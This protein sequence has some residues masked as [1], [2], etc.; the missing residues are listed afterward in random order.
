MIKV[1]IC[2]DMQPILRSIADKVSS[3]SS[4]IEIVGQFTNGK[5]ALESIPMLQPDIVFTDIRMPELD[6][7]QLIT[8]LKERNLSSVYIIFSGYND[9]QYARQ[10]LQLGVTEYLL[11]PITS[12]SITEI[13]DKTVPQVLNRKQQQ[14][15]YVLQYFLKENKTEG[16]SDEEIK[17]ALTADHFILGIFHAGPISKFD[18]HLSNPFSHFW[19]E[20]HLESFLQ[21]WLPPGIQ[22]WIFDSRDL[23]ELWVVFGCL[24]AAAP[25]FQQLYNQLLREYDDP[26]VP[27]TLTVSSRIKDVSGL[28]L[29]LQF[30]HTIMKKQMLFGRS[31]LIFTE[32][33]QLNAPV[34][35]VLEQG[36]EQ[37]LLSILKMNRKDDFLQT[38]ERLLLGW[39]NEQYTQKE[40]ESA[41]SSIITSC[42]KAKMF[43]PLLIS[44]INLELDE[45]ISI[46]A[47]YK[48]LYKNLAI[49][50][51]NIFFSHDSKEISPDS[52]QHTIRTIDSYLKEHYAEDISIHGIAE[53]FNISPSY[54]SREFKK[55]KGITPIEYLSRLRINKVKELLHDPANLKLKDIAAIVGYQNQYYLSKVFKLTTGMTTSEFKATGVK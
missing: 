27:L 16:V 51:D 9:F 5:A 53:Q 28:K 43:N 24:G 40:V 12:H 10:A 13:L 23:N 4:Q 47:D 21:K 6:G 55:Y 33:M 25:D 48:Q 49:L 22:S 52:I 34:R 38:I 30:S 7:L 1:V 44:D 36:N 46:S 54:L 11:K 41:L 50:F 14:Q 45:I 37:R 39:E 3:Y 17:A 18:I 20:H 26:G 31:S 42:C 8:G 35:S 19:I 15:K 2:E 32:N 29:E